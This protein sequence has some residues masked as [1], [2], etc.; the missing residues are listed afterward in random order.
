MSSV[1]CTFLLV[2]LA[3]LMVVTLVCPLLAILVCL[4]PGSKPGVRPCWGQEKFV[5]SITRSEL[6]CRPALKDV[7]HKQKPW[8][9][10]HLTPR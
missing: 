9:T 2:E 4:L 6:M 10:K 5:I 7:H 3:R 8:M 1:D